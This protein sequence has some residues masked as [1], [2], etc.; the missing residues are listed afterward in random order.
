LNTEERELLN[1]NDDKCFT[2]RGLELFRKT[3]AQYENGNSDMSE[4]EKKPLINCSPIKRRK[5][6]DNIHFPSILFPK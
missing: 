3:I 5:F 2:T 6:N 1:L 4:E